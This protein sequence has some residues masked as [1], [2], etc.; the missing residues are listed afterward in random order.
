MNLFRKHDRRLFQL[1]NGKLR[2]PYL[3]R[4]M[5]ALTHL[6]GAT[7]SI[8]LMLLLPLITEMTWRGIIALSFS[9]SVAAIMKNG[10]KRVR[11]YLRESSV[12]FLGK[13]LKDFSFPSGHTTA[14]FTCAI[15]LSLTWSGLAM[16]VVPLA[17]VVGWSRIYLGF[18]YPADVAAGAIIGSLTTW[19]IYW[20]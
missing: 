16:F 13:P 15:A 4:W 7:C 5:R 17:F 6:G 20:F 12:I 9:H 10:F 3:D 18:H 19:V 2:S 8:A 11:P 14:A 1:L